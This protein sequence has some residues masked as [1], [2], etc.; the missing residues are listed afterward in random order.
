[1][2][3]IEQENPFGFDPEEDTASEDHSHFDPI[4]IIS[5]GFDPVHKGHTALFNAA[6]DH[7]KVHVLLNSDDWLTRKKG[8]PFLTYEVRK[9]ILNNIS[10]IY[11]THIVDDR[12]DTVCKGLI[13]LRKDFPETK[14]FFAN[15]GDRVL[16][17]TPEMDFCE[18]L[19][20]D[21]LW[22]VG[23]DKIESSSSLLNKYRWNTQQNRAKHLTTRKWGTYEI[24]AEGEGYL[25]K[26]LTILPGKNISY[27]K[28][29]HR[30]EEWLVLEG[31]G[32]FLSNSYHNEIFHI[33]P[34]DRLKIQ[35]QDWHWVK[36]NSE[37]NPLC[38][39]ETW[40]GDVLEES[41][42]ERKENPHE[43]TVSE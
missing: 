5:G 8:V 10:S 7:G 15:G 20:I 28:H 14:L 31:T 24:L 29:T 32:D 1:M 43:I 33:N 42:I 27:Q 21:L 23:G 30:L 6:A 38:I 36:N 16:G 11:K 34:K 37:S 18:R 17:N 40:F 19:N 9:D 3:K 12:D 41:D 26:K 4:V 22:N 13:K 35:P 2:N 25:V 39:L